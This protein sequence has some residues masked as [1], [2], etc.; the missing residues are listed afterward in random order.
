MCCKP[1]AS[2][3]RLDSLQKPDRCALGTGVHV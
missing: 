1:A 2:F 3:A